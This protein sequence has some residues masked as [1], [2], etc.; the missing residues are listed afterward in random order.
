MNQ[1]CAT[2]GSSQP[3]R[4]RAASAMPTASVRSCQ[5]GAGTC[6]KW[7]TAGPAQA[8]RE[9]PT[10]R[11]QGASPTSQ[12][13]REQLARLRFRH[14]RADASAP[15]RPSPRWPA[16]RCARAQPAPAIRGSHQPRL[17]TGSIWTAGLATQSCLSLAHALDVGGGG[18]TK[19]RWVPK[20]QRRR[21]AGQR[22][23]ICGA[24]E[25]VIQ[26]AAERQRSHGLT[27]EADEVSFVFFGAG[28][29][30]AAAR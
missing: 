24:R 12:G 2:T 27:S 6:W 19:A 18:E 20:T 7:L 26:R 1:L 9:R 14:R 25:G 11:R 13:R 30:G 17:Q 28:A 21:H 8:R 29:R 16:W 5:N 4:A 15:A 3:R 10:A 22:A 23:R